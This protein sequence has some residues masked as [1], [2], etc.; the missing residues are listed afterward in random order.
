ML[1]PVSNSQMESTDVTGRTPM[2]PPCT[3]QH[4]GASVSDHAT[5]GHGRALAQRSHPWHCAF[6]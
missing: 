1:K 6:E 2:R 3:A 4:P 5:N